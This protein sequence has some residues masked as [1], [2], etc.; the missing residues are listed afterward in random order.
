MKSDVVSPCMHIPRVLS[1]LR[2]CAPDEVIWP[3]VAAA[4]RAPLIKRYPDVP[5]V[6]LLGQTGT[7]KTALAMVFQRFFLAPFYADKGFLGREPLAFFS[8][9]KADVILWATDAARDMIVVI[10]DYAMWSSRKS[11][12]RQRAGAEKVLLGGGADDLRARCLILGTGDTCDFSP[13]VRRNLFLIELDT[14][15]TCV[16]KRRPLPVAQR[17]S[18]RTE[19]GESCVNKTA[20]G[21]LQK[22]SEEGV[23]AGLMMD[24][25]DW[26]AHFDDSL[27][28]CPDA[29]NLD[30]A[31]SLNLGTQY[32]F[33]WL[34]DRGATLDDAMEVEA[35]SAVQRAGDLSAMVT[36]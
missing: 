1:A 14:P 25:V 5:V 36:G 26:L 2:S 12:N 22:M 21:A 3:L 15:R 7:F 10:D 23:L 24:Y 4:F 16:A 35:I 11:A 28:H 13:S 32:F 17:K 18:R 6:F 29:S 31:G 19:W 34:R 27:M 20:L 9:D 33:R 8:T 30:M